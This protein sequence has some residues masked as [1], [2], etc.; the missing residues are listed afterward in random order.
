MMLMVID[1]VGL[2][3][4]NA[5]LVVYMVAAY[6]LIFL[7]R[8]RVRYLSSD[9]GPPGSCRRPCLHDTGEAT[10]QKREGNASLSSEQIPLQFG[11]KWDLSLFVPSLSSFSLYLKSPL[12][13]VVGRAPPIL[14][15]FSGLSLVYMLPAFGAQSLAPC[16]WLQELEQI[17]VYGF[18]GK[19]RCK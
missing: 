9:D 3:A 4:H 18:R 11:T 7:S 2:W 12:E 19:K 16:I 8:V 10:V 17:V 5:V 14:V 15:G 13:R 1:D 6:G